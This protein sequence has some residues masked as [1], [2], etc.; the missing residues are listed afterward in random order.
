VLIN[1]C[2][3]FDFN[4]SKIGK[5]CR[6]KDEL[7][8]LKETLRG[9]YKCLFKVYKYYASFFTNSM[10]PCLSMNSVSDLVSRT[11]I[12]DGKRI[13]ANDIDV[14]FVSTNS[15]DLNY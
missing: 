14:L 15:K 11:S 4:S 3:E 13:K 1:D 5:I 8:V 7:L 2:F 9:Y 10:I 6:D 12:V